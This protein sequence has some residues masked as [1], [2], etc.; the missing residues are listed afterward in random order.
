MERGPEKL[1]QIVH[2]QPYGAGSKTAE[3]LGKIRR[4][5]RD[6]NGR[7]VLKYRPASKFTEP[8]MKLVGEECALTWGRRAPLDGS[9]WL[10]VIF[11]EARIDGHYFKRKTGRVLRP[12][13]P[14]HPAQTETHDVDKMRRAISDALTNCGV[15]VDD[16]R[17]VGGSAWKDY[18]ENH[19]ESI[20]AQAIIHLGV[21]K[22]QTVQDLLDAGAIKPPAPV[23]GQVALV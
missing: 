4:E 8:W 19:G 6:S 22:Q 20:G 23:E 17:I 13:A 7:I 5:V 21:M 11:L 2:S 10:D 14:A 15:I 1:K 16:K 9:L 18:A 12:D 3:P